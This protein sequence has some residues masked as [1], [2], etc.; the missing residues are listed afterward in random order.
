MGLTNTADCPLWNFH[1]V[2]TAV[3]LSHFVCS[4]NGKNWT[5]SLGE[6]EKLVI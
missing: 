5:G 1:S 4:V 3:C 2:F 6:F